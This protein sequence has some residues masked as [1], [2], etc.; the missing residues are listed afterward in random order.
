MLTDVLS[1]LLGRSVEAL[2]ELS[3]PIGPAEVCARKMRAFA[4]AGAQRVFIWPLADP[5]RQ[6][7]VFAEKVAPNI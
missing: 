7:E 6:L 3:L 4:A 1:P 2:R 5:V